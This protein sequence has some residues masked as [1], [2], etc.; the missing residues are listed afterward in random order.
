MRA[1][2]YPAIADTSIVPPVTSAAMY[3]EFQY[4]SANGCRANTR[5]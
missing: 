4:C 1:K 2:A 5:P 3:S